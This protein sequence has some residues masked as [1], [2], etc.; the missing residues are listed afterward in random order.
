MSELISDPLVWSDEAGGHGFDF[1]PRLVTTID[2]DRY[3][4]VFSM[5]PRSFSDSGPEEHWRPIY[6]DSDAGEDDDDW[7][8]PEFNAFAV[9][10]V[11]IESL[12]VTLTSASFLSCQI[13]CVSCSFIC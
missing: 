9:S 7:E 2:S 6:E 5:D 8:E 12:D 3:E 13:R 11:F 4:Q 10:P 1:M